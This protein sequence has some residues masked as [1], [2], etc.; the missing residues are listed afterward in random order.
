VNA[1]TLTCESTSRQS[2]A[3]A[4]VSFSCCCCLHNPAHLAACHLGSHLPRP[5]PHA[6]VS[7]PPAERCTAARPRPR[8]ARPARTAPRGLAAVLPH[9]PVLQMAGWPYIVFRNTDFGWFLNRRGSQIRPSP[10]E[11][12]RV[13]IRRVAIHMSGLPAR[14]TTHRHDVRLMQMKHV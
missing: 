11:P 8:C 13:L 12:P 6:R 4:T 9:A 10:F 3:A 5:L 1:R 14:L 2:V 7:P